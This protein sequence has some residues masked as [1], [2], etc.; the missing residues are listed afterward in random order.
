MQCSVTIGSDPRVALD[1]TLRVDYRPDEWMALPC[2]VTPGSILSSAGLALTIGE[3][4]N[5]EWFVTDVI[6]CGSESNHP[7]SVIARAV[8]RRYFRSRIPT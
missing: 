2:K 5:I 7:F 1:E 3:R 4:P 8:D 6:Q